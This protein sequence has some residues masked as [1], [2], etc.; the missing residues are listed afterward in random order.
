MTDPATINVIKETLPE[1][2]VY[3]DAFTVKRQRWGTFV[4]YDLEGNGIITSLTEELC[5]SATRWYLKAKQ[6]GFPEASTRYEGT[7]GGKL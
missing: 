2:P 4:S 7:V 6:E 1:S 3:D 5:I